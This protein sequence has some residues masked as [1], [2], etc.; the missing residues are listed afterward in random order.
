M[1]FEEHCQESERIFGKRYPEIHLWLDEFFPTLGARHRRKRHHEAGIREA[2]RI[3][4]PEA[5]PVARR[6]IVSDLAL[7]GWTENDPFP[8]DE[9]HYLRM[10]LF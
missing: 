8:R 6:H 9:E 7:E 4:G 1:T 3:F 5:E 10:G 2:V